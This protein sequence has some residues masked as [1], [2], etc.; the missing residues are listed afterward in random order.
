MFK[1]HETTQSHIDSVVCWD[2]YKASQSQGN[3]VQQIEKASA[4]EITERREYL[5]R[6]VAVT[7][8]LGKQ[9]IAF[10]GH[11]EKTDSENKGNFI[12]CMELLM[13]FDPFLQTHTPPS[14]TTYLSKASQNEM[15]ECYSK[16]VTETIVREM[17]ESG[18]YAIMADEARDSKTEQLALCVRYIV[19]G[20][21][22]E[23]FLGLTELKEF[24]A[25][26]ICAAIE[27]EL[28]DRGID[29]LK[30]VAQTY[31]GAAVMSGASGGVQAYFQNKHPEAIYVH[32]YAHELNLVLCHTCRAI[33]EAAELFNVL[34]SVHSFFSASLVNHHKFVETQQ[35]LGLRECE[36]V[37]LSETR[38]A[39]QVRSVNAVLENFLAITECLSSINTPLAVGL[40]AKLSNFHMVYLLHVFQVL[41]S[42]MAGF[43]RYLQKEAIDLADAAT[44]KN[45]VTDSLKEKRS[46]ATAVELHAR[47]KA[48]C[49]AD[50]VAI[51]EP[52][53]HKRKH[54]EGYVVESTCGAGSAVCGSSESDELKRKL[55]FPCV[56]RMI[57]NYRDVSLV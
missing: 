57:S 7:C 26:A 28:V 51:P 42:V 55:L 49:E 9:G 4:T 53:M 34:Q 3:V 2:S 25:K 18:M 8:M 48:F 47:T 43:H 40:K 5:K 41:L 17:K 30:C 19:E 32:C 24:G 37:Q 38:W 52:W 45:A 20:T 6:V 31:D 23:R 39:C 46:N 56:D 29:Q 33:S 22:K 11:D 10:R 36:L 12:E 50:Q 16:E 13:Q 54:M 14:N 35:K 21:V 27:K 15:I 1:K 44:H